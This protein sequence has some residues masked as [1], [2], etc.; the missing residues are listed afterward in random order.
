V[1]A[2]TSYRK[3]VEESPDVEVVTQSCL[4]ARDVRFRAE[5][6]VSAEAWSESLTRQSATASGVS[7]HG[8]GTQAPTFAHVAAQGRA[9]GQ[10]QRGSWAHTGEQG[11]ASLAGGP[12]QQAPGPA[13][14]PEGAKR[15]QGRQRARSTS[16]AA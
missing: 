15:R 7:P 9:V 12:A 5:R 3:A 11:V 4:P 10:C 13:R 16:P 1:L 8:F 6:Q 14:T 2:V